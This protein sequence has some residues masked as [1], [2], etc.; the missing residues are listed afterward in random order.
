MSETSGLTDVSVI[1]VLYRRRT[2]ATDLSL[3]RNAGAEVIVVDNYAQS[4]AERWQVDRYLP[5]GRNLGFARAA[6][7]GVGLASRSK[8]LFLNPDCDAP[9]SVL[10]ALSRSIEPPSVIA[11]AGPRMKGIGGGRAQGAAGF[12]P[13]ARRAL[14]FAFLAGP[15]LAQHALTVRGSRWTTEVDWVSGGC[16]MVRR[17][18]FSHAGGF[19]EQYFMYCEDM[20]LGRAM[21]QRGY[22]L[23]YR[24][25]LIV[26]HQQGGSGGDRSEID[27]MRGAS[28]GA[29][30]N[31]HLSWWERP[32]FILLYALGLVLRHALSV[33]G[34]TSTD[35]Q[36]QSVL[37]GFLQAAIRRE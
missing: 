29:Y 33:A 24:G 7:L 19:P 5:V 17:D 8:L 15:I 22:R 16:M 2:V 13:S 1:L 11:A 14:H 37:R 28:L 3:L 35:V 26:T 31:A 32:P 4:W 25:D 23:I 30:V 34:V 6:N 10:W 20:A 27:Q 21:R 12:E 36:H 9:V 18:A